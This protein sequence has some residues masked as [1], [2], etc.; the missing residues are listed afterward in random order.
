MAQNDPVPGFYYDDERSSSSDTTSDDDSEEEVPEILRRKGVTLDAFVAMKPKD[1]SKVFSSSVGVAVRRIFPAS[2]K[3]TT[4]NVA[5]DKFK[6]MMG[7]V[8]RYGRADRVYLNATFRLRFLHVMEY[9]GLLEFTKRC[10]IS[11]PSS[12]DVESVLNEILLVSDRL[13]DRSIDNVVY[14]RPLE[15]QRFKKKPVASAPAL[16][17]A[18]VDEFVEAC[19]QENLFPSAAG[20]SV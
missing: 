14:D 12:E 10:M 15:K 5:W 1:M 19:R 3:R 18:A 16:D 13:G 6:G 20:V 2:W 17:S 4:R 7:F 9:L 11:T 8:D